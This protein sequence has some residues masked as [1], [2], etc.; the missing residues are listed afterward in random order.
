[1]AGYTHSAF[2]RLL[3]DLGGCG[4]VWTE[5]LAAPQLLKEDVLSSPWL[6]RRPSDGPLVFQLMVR[7]RDPLDRILPRLTDHGVDALDLNLACDAFSIRACEA[8]SALF[9]NLEDL[10]TVATTT[11][12]LWPGLLTAKIRLGSRRPDWQP[13][14]A[15]RVAAL[16]DA[17]FD[18]LI[19]HPRFFEDKFRRAAR[20]DLLH[21]AASLTPLPLIANGDLAGLADVATRQKLLQPAHA[22]MI[23]RM[24]IAQPW[25]FAHW[26]QPR[27]ID[28]PALWRQLHD[29]ITE[30]FPPAAALRRLQMF[31]KYFAAN[32]AFGHRFNVD[33]ANAPTLD[34]LRQR[35]DR[36]FDRNPATLTYPVVA[37]L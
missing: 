25:L 22:I 37:G 7:A 21:W 23:G 14:F 20:H 10:R 2:R 13:R 32:F 18:A 28:L 35:A 26:H 3:A 19:V 9:E 30:D 27:P 24:A 1:M 36:F 11:R 17:G 16:T 4:A 29:Y 15:Q 8:G 12:R 33:L 6:R 31:S 5:M 34:T